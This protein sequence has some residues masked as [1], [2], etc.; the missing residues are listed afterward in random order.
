MSETLSDYPLR[1][2]ITLVL[3]AIIIEQF[4]VAYT[5]INDFKFSNIENHELFDTARFALMTS[6]MPLAV[7]EQTVAHALLCNA[8][9]IP[10]V[11]DSIIHLL[12]LD[13]YMSFFN[14]FEGSRQEAWFAVHS[15][16]PVHKHCISAGL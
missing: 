14:I 9:K 8:F 4:V 7:K 16:T 15:D 3:K 2:S 1:G 6:R 13:Q 11:P 12:T 10:Y 5:Y